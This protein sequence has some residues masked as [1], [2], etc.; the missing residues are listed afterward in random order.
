MQQRLYEA[1]HSLVSAGTMQQRLQGA[2]TSLAFVVGT[3]EEGHP[4]LE[5]RFRTVYR[6]L[7]REAIGPNGTIAASTARLTD[8]KASKIAR[9]IFA[10]FCRA[11]EL[12]RFPVGFE[13][14]GQSDE[15]GR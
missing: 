3:A 7:S 8:E 4:E 9:E 15:V 12:A 2:A 14:L 11:S 6:R 10:L 13:R 1:V 5:K